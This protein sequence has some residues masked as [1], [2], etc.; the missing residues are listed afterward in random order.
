MAIGEV[1][2]PAVIELR[3][4]WLGVIA[5]AKDEV[6]EDGIATRFSE[7]MIR[8]LSEASVEAVE[9]LQW[10]IDGTKGIDEISAQALRCA[11]RVKNQR[12]CFARLLLACRML[13]STS[14]T[15]RDGAAVA[16]ASMGD[17]SAFESLQRAAAVETVPEL[18]EDLE[19]VMRQ[20][21]S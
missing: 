4:R 15:I 11:A 19:A 17:S 1:N 2:L 3:Q 5:L 16:L 12:T 14:A 21:R 18:R 20:L 8:E 9:A 6:F 10:V 13:N 7:A